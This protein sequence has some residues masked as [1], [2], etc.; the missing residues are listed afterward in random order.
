L[1]R[2][3]KGGGGTGERKGRTQF[4]EIIKIS[5]GLLFRGIRET[6]SLWKGKTWNFLSKKVRLWKKEPQ[7][8]L[9][10]L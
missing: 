10:N 3:R 7:G 6:G 8:V 9:D 2:G 1:F 5:E 4:K